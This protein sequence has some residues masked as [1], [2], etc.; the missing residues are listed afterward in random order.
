MTV[1]LSPLAGAGQQFLDNSGDPLTGGLLYTYAA[2]TTTP[3]TTFT[4]IAGVTQNTNPILMDAAGRL[5]SEVWL[6]EGVAYKVV[7]RDSA[8]ALIGTYDDIYGI[9][10]TTTNG[11]PWA[12]I[13][14]TP[15][16]LAGYGIADSITAAVAASTYAPID[17]AALTGDTTIEDADATSYRAGYLDVPQVAK[18]TGYELILSD[19]G[20]SVVM[21]GSSLTLTIPANAATAFPIGTAIVVIN[22]NATS[23]SIAITTDTLTLVN[24]TT[25]GT[26]TLAQ[27]AMCTLIKTGTTAWLV[28]G[29]GVT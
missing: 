10:D 7:L 6:S 18:T 27:N 9:N 16:T 29:L 15:T 14:G 24:S 21:N 1:F 26:R 19:R 28:A 12:N 3:Q 4:T 22:I 20:K 17:D 5:E 23:L 25:T 11:V 2:G 8:G 13:S